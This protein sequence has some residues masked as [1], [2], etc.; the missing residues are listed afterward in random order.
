M[1]EESLFVGVDLG[2]SS[3]HVCCVDS[4]GEI[5]EALQVADGEQLKLFFE[6]L[7]G[8]I[9]VA[10]ETPQHPVVFAALAW[11]ANVFSVNP[12]T[13]DRFRDRGNPAG[14]KDDR[15]DAYVI[16]QSLRTDRYAF[17]RVVLNESALALRHLTRQRSSTEAK[18]RGVCNELRE[19]L[20][21]LM[22]KVT[23]LWPSGSSLWFY[24]LLGVVLGAKN[25]SRI[26]R[27]TIESI[28]RR[29]RKNSV[30]DIRSA[31][32]PESDLPSALAAQL[33]QSAKDLLAQVKL[34]DA[35]KRRYTAKITAALEEQESA[36]GDPP[37]DAQILNSIPGFGHIS[38][39][40]VLSEMPSAVKHTDLKLF[41]SLCGIAPV[42]RQSGRKTLVCMRRACIPQARNAMHHATQVAAMSEVFRPDYLRRRAKGQSH[43]RAL[44]GLADRLAKI[45]VGMLKTRTLFDPERHMT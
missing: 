29:Q 31:L 21:L 10:F 4:S 8:S 23:A 24:E 26:R 45:I 34:L 3:S 37:S 2:K 12:K 25:P 15:R 1:S 44:R 6:G 17:N 43:A 28:L 11:G 18:L 7:E 36:E 20:D 19:Q 38:T 9:S 13:V 41:R 42:T 30:E 39:A 16:A 32:K 22:P 27:T 35:Q 5:V 33:K 14:A 40:T